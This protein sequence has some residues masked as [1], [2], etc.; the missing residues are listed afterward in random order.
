MAKQQQKK[1]KVG[2]EGTSNEMK[3]SMKKENDQVGTDDN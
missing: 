3:K 1:Q 2:K